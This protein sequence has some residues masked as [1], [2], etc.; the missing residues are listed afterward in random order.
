[1]KR[2]LLSGLLITTMLLS[3]CNSSVSTSGQTDN[4]VNGSAASSITESTTETNE[5]TVAPKTYDIMWGDTAS[6]D[7]SNYLE[8]KLG[9]NLKA[10]V[11]LFGYTD[12]LNLIYSEYMEKN[13]GTEGRV[14]FETSNYFFTFVDTCDSEGRRV[15]RD[16]DFFSARYFNKDNCLNG[17]FANKFIMSYLCQN[18]IKFGYMIPV[19]YFKLVSQD[20]ISICL[21]YDANYFFENMKLGNF[22]HNYSYSSEETVALM[23]LYN[24]SLCYMYYS[25]SVKDHD[26]LSKPEAVEAFNQNLKKYYGENAPQIGQVVTVEQYRAM[27]GEDPLDLS[28]IPGAVVNQKAS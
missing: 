22:D 1:M 10:Y 7:F 17:I 4:S 9:I 24:N 27:F 18:N 3:A 13:Y 20:Y 15:Y 19:D 12:D 8:K 26:L 21:K 5:T 11:H 2:S 28:Y 14:S 6:Q 16:Y 25:E 23:K